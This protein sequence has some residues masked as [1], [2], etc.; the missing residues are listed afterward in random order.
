[1]ISIA[2]YV[3]YALIEFC[4]LMWFS[5]CEINDDIWSTY[6]IYNIWASTMLPPNAPSYHMITIQAP[7]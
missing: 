5:Q 3:W 7:L 4:N 1:M 6:Q 2:T